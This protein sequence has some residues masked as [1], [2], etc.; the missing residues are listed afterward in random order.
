LKPVVAAIQDET[1]KLTASATA[2]SEDE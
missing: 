2:V 1:S